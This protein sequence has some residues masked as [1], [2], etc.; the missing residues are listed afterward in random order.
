[1][2]KTSDGQEFEL[3][4]HNTTFDDRNEVIQIETGQETYW[5]AGS[6]IVYCW[7]HRKK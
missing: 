2:V 6:Q 4:L 3:H 7:I 5:L 1:M